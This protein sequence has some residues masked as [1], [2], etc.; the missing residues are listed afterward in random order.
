LASVRPRRI[1]RDVDL[2]PVG[3]SHAA[4]LLGDQG[5]L[6]LAQ[7]SG[8]ADRGQ[9]DAVLLAVELQQ[10]AQHG[11][12]DADPLAVGEKPQKIEERGGDLGTED[13]DQSGLL[14]LHLQNGG[15]HRVPQRLGLLPQ[16]EDGAGL[17]DHRVDL[18]VGLADAQEGVGVGGGDGVEQRHQAFPSDWMD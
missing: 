8:G 13:L 18:A 6:G 16:G 2:H 9:G 15:G 5:L 11:I 7:G 14:G 12:E 17:V 4:G 1:D 3:A 10:P